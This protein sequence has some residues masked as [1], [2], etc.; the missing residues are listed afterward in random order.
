MCIPYSQQSLY[1]D[2]SKKDTASIC[3]LKRLMFISQACFHLLRS[4]IHEIY[5]D[6]GTL[7]NDYIIVLKESK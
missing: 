1:L 4:Y 6:Q 7:S 5:P 3:E 2:L